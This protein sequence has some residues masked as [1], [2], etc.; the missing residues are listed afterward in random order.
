MA[1]AAILDFQ[2]FKILTVDPLPGAKCVTLPNF[3]KNRPNGR[4]YMA[5]YRFFSKWRPSAILDLLGAYWDHP[6]RPLH[7]LYRYA[8]FGYNRCSSFDNMKLSR[9]CPFGLKTPTHAPKIGVLGYFTSKMRSNINETPKR[10][11]HARQWRPNW[12]MGPGARKKFH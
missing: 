2:K 12:W 6:R 5:I 3:I 8:K 10:H 9:F 11:I 4:R 1:T 7:C